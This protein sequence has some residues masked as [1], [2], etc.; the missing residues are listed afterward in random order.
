MLSYR[1]VACLW[2]PWHVSKSSALRRIF[3][4]AQP[5]CLRNCAG[6]RRCSQA[7]LQGGLLAVKRRR[8]TS[9]GDQ[10]LGFRSPRP[11]R[12]NSELGELQ[13]ARDALAFAVRVKIP[14][15]TVAAIRLASG[16]GSRF[17]H[18]ELCSRSL[19]GP[20]TRARASAEGQLGRISHA[21]SCC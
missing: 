1:R 15:T 17:Q 10:W 3:S 21:P 20:A 13:L 8:Q 14:C 18:C 11:K 6:E 12:N 4:F 2:Y 9:T 16:A 5:V 7:S 19:P